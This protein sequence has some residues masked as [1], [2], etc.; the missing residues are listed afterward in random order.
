[1]ENTTSAANGTAKFDASKVSVPLTEVANANTELAVTQVKNLLDTCFTET[2]SPSGGKVYKP[3]T[4]TF[5]IQ[6]SVITPGNSPSTQEITTQFELPLVT[7][8]PITMLAI[9]R[10]DIS[11]N[12]R[13]E[14]DQATKEGK[15]DEEH[16]MKNYDTILHCQQQPLPQGISVLINALTNTIQPTSAPES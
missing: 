6:R 2:D 12:T 4:I 9:D 5:E 14:V 10:V 7:A 3:I 15:K 1:M 16:F 8:M 11:S 13:H